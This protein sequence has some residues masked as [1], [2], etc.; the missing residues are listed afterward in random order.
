ME[1]STKIIMLVFALW[2]FY[3]AARRFRLGEGLAIQ[4]ADHA[5]RIAFEDLIG[6]EGDQV[7]IDR[8]GQSA[9]V[10]GGTDSYAFIRRHGA[11]FVVRQISGTAIIRCDEQQILLRHPDLPKGSAIMQAGHPAEPWAPQFAAFNKR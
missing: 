4:D 9:L 8:T 6:F 3:L 7:L 1:I 10:R 5:K 11:H 2:A